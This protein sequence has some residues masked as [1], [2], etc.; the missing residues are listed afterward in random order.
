MLKTRVILSEV[1]NLSDARYAAGMGVDYIGFAINPASNR[2]VTAAQAGA[3]SEWLSGV[4]IIGDIGDT[5]PANLSEYRLDLIQTNN[6]GLLADLKAGILAVDVKDATE[7]L[8]AR[9][10]EQVV[11]FVLYSANPEADKQHLASLCRQ[12]P[13][14]LATEFTAERLEVVLNAIQ[15]AGIVLRG[16]EEEKPG[17][18]NYDGIADIL[19][20]LEAE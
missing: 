8:L 5:R 1:V 12:F 11:F 6:E 10:K 19:E 3:I 15:P 16:S 4:E 18:S 13:V 20:L 14:F 2:L 17:L 9:Y 7:R